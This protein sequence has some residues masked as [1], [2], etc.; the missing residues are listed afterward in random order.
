MMSRLAQY[1]RPSWSG[2]R[3]RRAGGLDGGVVQE[4]GPDW[5]GYYAWSAG[6][7]PLLLAACQK[8]SAGKDRMAIDLGCGDGTQALELLA[9][10]WSVMAVDAARNPGTRGVRG[11]GPTQDRRPLPA[12]CRQSVR[13]GA[14]ASRVHLV[15]DYLRAR[16]QLLCLTGD[17]ATR[18]AY[19]YAALSR[20]CHYHLYEPELR[21]SSAGHAV[22]THSMRWI[23]RIGRYDSGAMP[24][25]RRS[26]PTLRCLTED[27]GVSIP[28]LEVDLG[29]LA[30][31]W[32]DEL[33]RIAPTSPSGQKRILSIGRPMVYRLRASSNRAATWVDEDRGIVWLCAAHRREEGSGDDAY[34]WFARLHTA[35]QLLP[36]DDDRLRDRAEAIIRLQRGLTS[37]LLHLADEALIREGTELRSDLGRYLPCRVLALGGS[38]VEEIWCALSVRAADGTHIGYELRN[39]LFAALE[40]HFPDAIFEVRGD[41]PTGDVGWWE[42]VRLGLR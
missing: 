31:P 4:G 27:L 15:G 9:R 25:N 34:A 28:P 14:P 33:R 42:T 20:A 40:A 17:T 38:G 13:S 10:G 22:R 7:E 23:V 21:V 36:S 18:A 32:L 41:W 35:G 24:D 29:G 37:E 8:L 19:L 12:P 11:P 5:A 26:R 6:R 3:S 2:F 1:S 39:I 16:S 30:N